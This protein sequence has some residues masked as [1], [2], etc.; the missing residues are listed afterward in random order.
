[1]ACVRLV[2]LKKPATPLGFLSIGPVS[3]GEAMEVGFIIVVE[4][5]PALEGVEGV[6]LGIG[7]R[8]AV[9]WIVV[10]RGHGGHSA[11]A[12]FVLLC[13][14]VDDVGHVLGESVG[15]LVFGHSFHWGCAAP[16]ISMHV[17]KFVAGEL[18]QATLAAYP[19]RAKSTAA[20]GASIERLT[21]RR[22]RFQ[23]SVV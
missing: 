8:A 16:V 1:M 17:V 4:G 20:T 14:L 18:G 11:T 21:M 13:S 12:G 15:A 19:H 9:V 3:T 2:V 23:A 22:F 7:E 10:V 5:V 6:R